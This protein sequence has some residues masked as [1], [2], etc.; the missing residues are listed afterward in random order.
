MTDV[1]KERLAELEEGYSQSQEGEAILARQLYT[2]MQERAA[3]R[4]ALTAADA[5]VEEA[6]A[7][8]VCACNYDTPTD[9][10]L[11]HH[12]LFE[13][14]YAVQRGKLDA[15]IAELTAALDLQRAEMLWA[16]PILQRYLTHPNDQGDL[17]DFEAAIALIARGDT[18]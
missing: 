15:R 4:D 6:Q 1:D 3:L 14:L 9:V 5:R 12:R 10:C 8:Q 18:P 16:L 17:A 11:G 13:R 2:L 7:L